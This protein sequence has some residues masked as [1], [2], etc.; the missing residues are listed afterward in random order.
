MKEND[1]KILSLKLLEDKF[2]DIENNEISSVLLNISKGEVSN[3]EISKIILK[4][5]NDVEE[6]LR[7]EE[8]L[9][10]LKE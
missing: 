2:K 9:N 10:N 4:Y 8:L 3:K 1:K 6:F 5:T 7:I